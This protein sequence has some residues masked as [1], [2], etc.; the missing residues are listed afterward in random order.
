MHSAHFNPPSPRR[1][2]SMFL[3]STSVRL[4]LSNDTPIIP[5]GYRY[6]CLS[7]SS[8]ESSTR[9]MFSF[10]YDMLDSDLSTLSCIYIYP[11]LPYSLHCAVTPKP[12][13]F[14][15][16]LYLFP[17]SYP[18]PTLHHFYQLSSMF[19]LTRSSLSRVAL[20]RL[21][22]SATHLSLFFL[23][24]KVERYQVS[25]SSFTCSFLRRRSG[26][27]YILYRELYLRL[28]VQLLPRVAG[29]VRSVD[30]IACAVKWE[31]NMIYSCGRNRLSVVCFARHLY[32]SAVRMKE[33]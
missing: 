9:S 24:V 8:G 4:L 33:Y 21:L 6:G 25:I 11:S 20:Y 2:V 18:S 3:L 26:Y 22:T 27:W 30:G 23:L 29:S 31:I 7:P 32:V 10:C 17:A 5:T 12:P 15:P 1:Y 14:P 16:T 13:M 28:S 19:S